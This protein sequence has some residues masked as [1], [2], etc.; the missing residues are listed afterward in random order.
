MLAQ[1]ARGL[2]DRR[3]LVLVGFL[4]NGVSDQKPFTASEAAQESE[5][6]ALEFP[7]R[8]SLSVIQLLELFLVADSANVR[9]VLEQ[10]FD[11]AAS[12][13]RR[14]RKNSRA[15]ALPDAST[16]QTTDPQSPVAARS[17]RCT[18]NQIL[19]YI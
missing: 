19:T 4:A 18:P 16:A 13:S 6:E 14:F 10:G 15:D 12:S 7:D 1:D 3:S 8:L 11:L 9:Q 2:V 17:S 5:L